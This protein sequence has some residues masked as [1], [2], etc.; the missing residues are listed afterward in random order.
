MFWAVGTAEKKNSTAIFALVNVGA[1]RPQIHGPQIHQ[2]FLAL[3]EGPWSCEMASCLVRL[4]MALQ[5]CIATFYFTFA[6]FLNF[7]NTS[8]L[9]GRP[10][11]RHTILQAR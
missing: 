3:P 4:L 5:D 8:R 9:A 7:Q 11:L 2:I 10:T 6:N 1:S